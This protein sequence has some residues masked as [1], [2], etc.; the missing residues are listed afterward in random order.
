MSPPPSPA[1]C[2]PSFAKAIAPDTGTEGYG[3][4][5]RWDEQGDRFDEDCNN[6]NTGPPVWAWRSGYSA[7]DLDPFGFCPWCGAKLEQVT[8]AR[9]QEG[10]R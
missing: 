6:L 1:P 9:P 10:R 7:A 3:R 5:V 8:A 2:C 4:L